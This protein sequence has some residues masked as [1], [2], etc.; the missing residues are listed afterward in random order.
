MTGRNKGRAAVG[1]LALVAGLLLPPQV[2]AQ[3]S[4]QGV[5]Q[6]LGGD[7]SPDKLL[8]RIDELS[9]ALQQSEQQNDGLQSQLGGLQAALGDLQDK[10]GSLLSQVQTLQTALSESRLENQGLLSQMGS[11]QSAVAK[12]E[13]DRTAL[14]T[15]VANL[16]Q[17]LGGRTEELGVLG[18][19]L[20]ELVKA[21]ETKDQ[22]IAQLAGDLSGLKETDAA[23]ALRL[24]ALEEKTANLASLLEAREAE[25]M[26]LRQS[27][28]DARDG[29]QE[30]E[31]MLND[32]RLALA[33]AEAAMRQ[34]MNRARTAAAETAAAI[35]ESTDMEARIDALSEQAEQAGTA[36]RVARDEVQKRAMELLDL[37]AQLRR[38]ASEAAAQRERADTLV[39]RLGR[40]EGM[41]AELLD[42]RSSL[43]I[44]RIVLAVLLVASLIANV[45]MWRRKGD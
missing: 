15:Q 28:A 43:N 13:Q 6:Q 40:V 25:V 2:S 8:A 9:N 14:G 11:L 35:S 45:L 34:Q 4:L 17:T 7:T 36:L 1:A 29:T 5:L 23:R 20:S 32:L 21:V 22:R 42:D 3:S 18:D 16:Q 19:R 33:D 12:S 10:N 24:A 38:L 26:R 39:A 44:Q 31:G 41:Q 30:R 37:Q 27:L